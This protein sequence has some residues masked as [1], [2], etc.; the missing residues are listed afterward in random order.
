M[1]EQPDRQPGSLATQ[2]ESAQAVILANGWSNDASISKAKT[3]LMRVPEPTPTAGRS[4]LAQFLLDQKVLTREQAMDL[5]SI[6]LNQKHLPN[7]QLLKKLGSGGMGVVYLARHIATGRTC[8]LKTINARLADDGDFVNRF[9]RETEALSAVRHDHIA[10]VIETG[11]REGHFYL[12]M[13]YIDGPSLMSL[14]K[15]YHALPEL[16][17]LRIVRQLADGLGY[18]YTAAGLIHRDLKP[19]NVLIVRSRNSHDLF[20]EDDIAKLIDFGLVKSMDDKDERLTQTGMTI[21]TPL[22]MSPEQVRGEALD[23][24]SDIYGL[25]ATLY[26]LVTGTTPY[27]GSSPG[28]IMSAHLTQPIPDPSAKVPSLNPLTRSLIM[29]AMAKDVGDR[30]LNYDGLIKTLD[31]AIAALAGQ[32]AGAPKLLLKPLVLKGAAAAAAARKN[33]GTDRTA[34]EAAESAKPAEVAKPAA[35]PPPAIDLTLP[36][37]GSLKPRDDAQMSDASRANRIAVNLPD[38]DYSV[39]QPPPPPAGSASAAAAAAAPKKPAGPPP[40]GSGIGAQVAPPPGA[41]PHVVG[42]NAVPLAP[43]GPAKNA[44]TPSGASAITPETSLSPSGS[45]VVVMPGANG[46]VDETVERKKLVRP[47]APELVGEPSEAE[48]ALEKELNDAK[49]AAQTSLAPWIFLAVAVASLIAYYLIMM[50]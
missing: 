14:L 8:A 3:A 16:Y 19:E 50:R 15:D 1:T 7:F 36:A 5:D 6:V 26:H 17:S 2:L 29:T 21:G 47:V 18:V 30:F 31:K 10:E 44:N 20:P 27:N 13:E 46:E 34:R 35:P 45:H 41:V 22:Y 39:P 23:C 49:K 40:P 38:I 9:H 4:R 32:T 25:G 28:T 33:Q 11:E 24:R 42:K 48:R 43:S 37:E 12:A